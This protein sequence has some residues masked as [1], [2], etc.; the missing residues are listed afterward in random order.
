MRQALG[1]GLAAAALVGGPLQAPAADAAE[2]RCKMAGRT[3]VRTSAIR[4]VR[5]ELPREDRVVLRGCAFAANRVVKL[6]EAI[7]GYTRDESIRLDEHAGTWVGTSSSSSSQYGLFEATRITNL[8]NRRS[9]RLHS[10]RV[11]VTSPGRSRSLEKYALNDRGQVA[12]IFHAYRPAAN[13]PPVA[14]VARVVAVSSRGRRR[15]VDVGAPADIPASS[16]LLDRR[17]F[18]W[19]HAG[20]VR[21]AWL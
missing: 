21:Y 17:L 8:R 16:L 14:T 19:T 7:S 10:E 20:R 5:V 13:Q 18:V 11:D 9:Y 15:V 3:V 4:V 2:R 12:A 1:L 6:G